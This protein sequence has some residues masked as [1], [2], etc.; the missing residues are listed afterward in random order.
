MTIFN[1][2]EYINSLPED[3]TNINVKYKGIA[4]LPDITKFKNI[5]II[6]CNDNALTSLPDLPETL[7][8]LYCS[9]NQITLLPD[10]PKNLTI[11]KCSFTKLTSLPALPENLQQLFC[12]HNKL[13]TLHILPEN[14]QVLHCGCN[15][16]TT[17]P[18]L[19]QKIQQLSCE[20]NHLTSLPELPKNLKKI[21]CDHNKLI[22][23]PDLPENLE[24]IYF[25]YNKIYEL[26]YEILGDN[27]HNTIK[28]KKFIKLLNSLRTIYYSLK[29]KNQFRDWLWIRVRKPKIEEMF[30]P[31][32]L[33]ER[34]NEDTDLDTVLNNW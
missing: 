7:E 16:L 19:P 20:L 30:H 14:L 4:Y 1:I 27:M 15:Q 3:I 23:L 8:E 5:K 11:L 6:Y 33:M 17:L 28:L 13:T 24:S 26:T 32:H 25:L 12:N 34:L 10:L 18:T 2:E 9:Y 31:K 22:M 29:F 21:R